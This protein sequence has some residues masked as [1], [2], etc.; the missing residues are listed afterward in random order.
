MKIELQVQIR[1]AKH[2]QV[3]VKNEM[4]EQSISRTIRGNWRTYWWSTGPS[5]GCDTSAPDTQHQIAIA[6]VT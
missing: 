5:R 2:V 6:G 3:K 4:Y 1:N